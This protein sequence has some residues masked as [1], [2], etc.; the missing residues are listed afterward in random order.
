MFPK[1]PQS[2]LRILRV[3]QEHPLPLN[4]PP[5]RIL[6]YNIQKYKKFTWRWESIKLFVSSSKTAV[7]WKKSRSCNH[8]IG[9]PMPG[10]LQFTGRCSPT[11]GSSFLGFYTIQLV[12]EPT[13]LKN[14]QIGSFPRVRV[15]IQEYLKP[16]PST[17]FPGCRFW[18]T[19]TYPTWRKGTSC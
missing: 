8:L 14:S 5:L 1:V 7:A 2:S 10:L 13:H 11:N 12:E 4:T 16:P 15:K 9:N 19:I 17:I 3:P 18:K 6:E